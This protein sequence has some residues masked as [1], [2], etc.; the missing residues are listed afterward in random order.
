M[1]KV[2]GNGLLIVVSGP[3]GAGKDTICNKIIEDSDNIWLSVSMTSRN[4]RGNEKEG[5]NYFF[6]TK[7]EFEQKI[8]DGKLLE[9]TNY[10]GNYYGTPKDKLEDYLNRGIDVI[11]VLDIN[12]AINIKK[13]VPSALF[14]FIM[15]PDMET[16]KKRLIARKTESKEKV[17]A[18]FTEAYNEINSYNKYNYVVVNDKIENAVSK[19]KAIIQA[20]KCRVERIE[21]IKL[22]NKEEL[23]HEILIDKDFNND[24]MRI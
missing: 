16:L 4:P 17:I 1:L 5:K 12:G 7:E 11:L 8:K 15:P 10:N 21:E 23:I 18:R 3:S 19:V 14:I 24:E 2:D 6:V 22:D 13:L 9:Y 20:E